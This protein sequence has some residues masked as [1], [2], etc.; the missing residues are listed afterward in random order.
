MSNATRT[1]PHTATADTSH[2]CAS[3]LYRGGMSLFAIQELLGHAWTGNTTRYIHVQ[4][5][6]IE[7]AWTS[8]QHRAGDRWKGLVR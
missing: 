2:N 3:Q 1:Q 5:S 8:G 6:H 7:D 4:S